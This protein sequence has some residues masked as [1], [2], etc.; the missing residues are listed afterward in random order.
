MNKLAQIILLIVGIIFFNSCIKTEV[1]GIKIG[2]NLYDTQGYTYNR[3]LVG[4]IK[5][6]LNKDEKSIIQLM[7]FSCGGAAGCYDLGYVL[8]QIVYKIG[9]EDFITMTNKLTLDQKRNLKG[10]IDVGLEYGDNRI[11]DKTGSTTID[12]VFPKLHII[13][14]N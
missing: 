12:K 5:Q 1:E 2:H 8:V 6:A 14:G 3:E 7:E 11:F 9:E 13:L 4:L 10:F